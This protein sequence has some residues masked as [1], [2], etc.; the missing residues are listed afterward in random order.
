[1]PTKFRF[2]GRG[3]KY[4]NYTWQY[5][6]FNG[7]QRADQSWLN[8]KGGWDFAP[9]RDAWDNLMGCEIRYLDENNRDEL[10]RWGQWLTDTLKLDGYRLDATRHMYTPFVNQWLD[11]VKG[12]RFAV[13]EA[14]FYEVDE[15]RDYANRT[16][17]RTSL[18]DFP[19]HKAFADTLNADGPGDLRNLRFAGFT[20]V[21]GPLSVSF[22]E[23]HDTDGG[24][25][26][27][28]PTPTC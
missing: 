15:L 4:S 13:S 6:N 16:G 3:D 24:Y 2:S 17:R 7:L 18:F 21:D 22:V 28:W 19:L 20:E 23:N 9:Y 12:P 27:G 14:A 26:V 25:P 11:Q 10:V 8:W 5:Y 1:V